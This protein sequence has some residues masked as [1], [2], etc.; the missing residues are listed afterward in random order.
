[1]NSPDTYN[2]QNIFKN[3]SKSAVLSYAEHIYNRLFRSETDLE[4]TESCDD[5]ATVAEKTFEEKLNAAINSVNEIND[6]KSMATCC[7]KKNL[8]FFEGCGKKP[9]SVQN[10]FNALLT[11]QPTSVESERIFSLA[12][13][14]L[15]KIR[16]RLSDESINALSV[17]KTHYLNKDE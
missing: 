4:R 9:E 5:D 14:F 8:Q 1:M 12:G 15:T 7:I 17:L 13:L 16:N 3:A 10:L 2:E 6:S 11:I